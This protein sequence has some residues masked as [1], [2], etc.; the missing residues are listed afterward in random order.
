M[1]SSTRPRRARLT[2][3]PRLRRSVQRTRRRNSAESGRTLGGRGAGA[4]EEGRLEIVGLAAAADG[5]VAGGKDHG[6]GVGEAADLVGG[7]E[8]AGRG[9]AWRAMMARLGTRTREAP[10]RERVVRLTVRRP[11]ILERRSA[12]WMSAGE[13][14]LEGAVGGDGLVVAIDLVELHGGLDGD[15]DA[16]AVAAEWARRPSMSWRTARSAEPTSMERMGATPPISQRRC[17]SWDRRRCGSWW[18]FGRRCHRRSRR[19]RR[20]RLVRLR[21]RRRLAGRRRRRRRSGWSAWPGRHR[22]AVDDERSHR[23]RHHGRSRRHR[24]QRRRR[25]KGGLRL[26]ERRRRRGRRGFRGSRT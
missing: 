4:G 23:R 17:R 25:G 20:W 22:C 12:V 9:W 18:R 13:G 21:A 26:L 1:A 10:E 19:R 7:E 15:V 3:S 8:G 2:G 5:G 14:D 11:V 6:L 24:R 16:D